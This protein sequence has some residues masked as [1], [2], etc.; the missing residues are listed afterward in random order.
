MDYSPPGSLRDSPGK[1]TGVGCHFLLQ[2]IFP[3]QGLNPHLLHLLYWQADSVPQRHLG[4]DCCRCLLSMSAKSGLL[5][6]PVPPSLPTNLWRRW[7]P[8]LCMPEVLD[9]L[10][11][12]LHLNTFSG[13][14][15]FSPAPNSPRHLPN[16]GS[17]SSCPERRGQTLSQWLGCFCSAA[18][19]SASDED[20][21]GVPQG[22]QH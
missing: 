17:Q 18:V 2:G 14:T 19:A 12:C 13:R 16:P 7:N 8:D 6:H 10:K 21:P 22:L 5:G 1:N 4:E 20:E 9:H 15:V 3:T 11:Q